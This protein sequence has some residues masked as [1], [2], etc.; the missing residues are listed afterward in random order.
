MRP[1][2]LILWAAAFVFFFLVA[3]GIL[4]GFSA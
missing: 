2:I 1:L 3:L 4:F